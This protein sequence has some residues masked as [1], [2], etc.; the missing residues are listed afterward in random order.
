MS[1]VPATLTREYL[2]MGGLLVNG[3]DRPEQVVSTLRDVVRQTDPLLPE[4]TFR[5]LSEISGDTLQ[6]QRFNA[7]L[8]TGFAALALLL[9][10]IGL[11]GVQGYN[12]AQR[13]HEIGVRIALGAVPGKVVGLVVR[14]GFAWIALGLGVGLV[15]ALALTNLLE[16]MLYGIE[17][18]D[19]R[20][21]IA[22]VL[23]LVFVSLIVTYLPARRA[24]QLDPVAALR[25]E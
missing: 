21:L 11:Y 13:T 1:Q 19:T 18:S 9:T 7:A 8:M 16:G 14:Q 12:I 2:A 5:S 6:Q 22:A 3:G 4:P 24:T 15:G 17:A 25:E 23:L 10:A 20:A